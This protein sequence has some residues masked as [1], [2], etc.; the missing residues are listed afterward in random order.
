MYSILKTLSKAVQVILA[1]PVKL[2]AKV[3]QAAKY[4]AIALGILEAV[5]GDKDE[6]PQ[7]GG[8]SSDEAAD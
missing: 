5:V 2:P 4:V 8:E 3:M 1:A 7:T 6:K